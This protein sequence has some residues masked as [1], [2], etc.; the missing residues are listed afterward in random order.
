MLLLEQ[1]TIRK[2]Q[3]DKT[4][5]EL[6]KDLKF[7]AGGNK[8]YKVK[9]IINSAAYGQQTND[10]YQMSGFYY[11]VSWKSYPEKKN[12]WEPLLVVIH[13]QKLINTFYKKYLKKLTI[14]SLPLDSVLPIARP[15]I[16]KKLKQKHGCSSKRANKK[17]RK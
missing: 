17:G 12:T 16:S 7:E 4:L 5:P 13:L 3:V 2:W 1:N 10:S 14:T 9:V 15:S 6:E 11:L 8:E